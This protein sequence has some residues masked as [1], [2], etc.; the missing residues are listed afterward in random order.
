M[1]FKRRTPLPKMDRLCQMF[2]PKTGWIRAYH[3]LR[4]RILR[5]K[6]GA[7]AV[8]GGFAIG[9]AV[10]FTPFVGTHLLQA[11]L[12]CLIF[13]FNIL[14]GFAGTLIGNPWTFPVIFWANYKIGKFWFEFFDWVNVIAL[15]EDITLSVLLTHPVQLMLPLVVGGLVTAPIAFILSY[16]FL[17]FPVRGMQYSY[18]LQKLHRIRQRRNIARGHK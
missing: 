12:L 7:H 3:Y 8:T 4:H 1:L 9:I 6:P 17:Y 10:S 13:R 15:P 14:A 11:F 2:W 18:R 5:A 16:V